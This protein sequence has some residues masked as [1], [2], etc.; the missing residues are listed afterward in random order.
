MPTYFITW[1]TRG[2]RLAGDPR[3]S[4]DEDHRTPG[5]PLADVN[6]RR[7]AA[8]RSRLKHPPL[9]LS[10]SQRQLLDRTIQEHCIFRGWS[11]HALNVRT[12]HIH[13]VLTA[14]DPPETVM[15]KLKIRCTLIL[16][17]HGHNT[18]K[19]WTDHGSTRWIDSEGS[20]QLAIRYVMEIQDKPRFT[21]N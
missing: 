2:T 8:V 11:L 15:Q 9:I 18:P 5:K 16:N 17:E 1:T 13:V 21:T 20:L 3:G 4:V 10:S 14:S 6:P 12:N 7:V 19:P